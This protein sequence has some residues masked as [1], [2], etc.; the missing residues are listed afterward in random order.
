M[1]TRVPSEQSAPLPPF[2]LGP[3][4]ILPWIAAGFLVSLAVAMIALI[5]AGAGERGTA[6]ALRVTA[7][8]CFLLFWL[9]YAG[10]ALTRFCGARFAILA[11]QGREIGF[12]F[13]AALL[14]HVG[15][16]LWLM[17]VAADQRTP[18]LVFWAGVVC[19]YALA[20]L[21]QPRL[22]SWLGSRVWRISCEGAMQYIAL[23][24]VVDFIVEPLKA[25]GPD[26]YPPTYL[27]FA[28]ML[29]GGAF[30]RFVAQVQRRLTVQ[31]A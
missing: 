4:G 27:P 31:K 22:R 26:K 24:F 16:V 3:I 8:W 7:R 12:A 28:I 15:L 13:A 30:L 21:S 14:V 10:G 11:R 29:V 9:A 17:D 23:V 25:N 1:T 2:G 20:L 19:T 18:M 6:L 5:Y